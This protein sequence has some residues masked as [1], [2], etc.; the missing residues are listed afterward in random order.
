MQESYTLDKFNSGRTV[1]GDTITELSQKDD[2]IWLLT[3]DI[4]WGCGDFKKAHPE[5]FIDTGIAEQCVVGISSG[6][7]LEGRIPYIIGMMPF[8]SMRAL[9]Q[10]RTDLCYP[11]LPVRIIANYSGLTGNGGSTHYAMEDMALF[12]SLVNMTVCAPADPNQLRQIILK[13]VDWK[14]PMA[15]RM[16]PGKNNAIL[17][18]DDAEFE[19]GKAYIAQE[20]KDI[21]IIACGEMVSEAVKISKEMEKQGVSVGVIDM[22]T[23]KPLDREAVLNAAKKTG[24]II[25]W[26]DH[27]TN[28]GLSSAVSDVITDN[29][30]ALKSFKRFGIPQV[31][32]GFGDSQELYHKYGYDGEAVITYIKELFQLK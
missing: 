5:R 2:R 16:D 26:E 28:N 30:V 19:I 31:Y 22:F 17:Y 14:G 8:M 3:P 25:T 4:G 7:A 24:R 20:G 21:T 29:C 32:P 6:L 18:P 15:I 1:V 9:E 27:L 23:I 10:V 12:S 13:S 11:N